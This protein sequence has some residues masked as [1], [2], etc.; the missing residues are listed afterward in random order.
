MTT[1]TLLL[2]TLSATGLVAQAQGKLIDRRDQADGWY[3]PVICNVMANGGK[4]DSLSITVFKDNTIVQELAPARKK[5]AVQ[6]DLDIDA[7]YTVRVRKEGYREKLI[8]VDTHLP[9]D[10]VEYRAYTCHVN[11]EPM[12]RFT[13]ADPFYLDFPSSIVRWSEEKK[14]FDHNDE[15]LTDIQVKM[16]LLGAQ[17]DVND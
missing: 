3:P 10:Q 8:Y 6:L 14:T 17:I 15:Y 9:A 4:T 13:H 1:R 11:L 16:A 5:S 12:D 7:Q 2:V